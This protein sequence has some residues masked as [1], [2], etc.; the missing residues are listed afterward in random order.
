VVPPLY[1]QN[2]DGITAINSADTINLAQLQAFD[3]YQDEPMDPSDMRIDLEN[4]V[5]TPSEQFDRD[6]VKWQN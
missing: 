6:V 3:N 5:F 1:L 2:L 4:L